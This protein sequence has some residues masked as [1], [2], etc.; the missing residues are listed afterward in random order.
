M[1]RYDF[2]A[3]INAAFDAASAGGYRFT[4]SG[5]ARVAPDVEALH[6]N[7]M[8]TAWSVKYWS[9]DAHARPVVQ[10]AIDAALQLVI[11]QMSTWDP[12]S[13]LSRFNAAQAGSMHAL[14]PELGTVLRHALDM[15]RRTGGA[16][17]PTI[18]PL[19]NLWGFGPRDRQ[20]DG[21]RRRPTPESIAAARARCG[22][23]KVHLDDEGLRQPGGLYIDLS[24]IAKGFAVDL[25]SAR[26]NALGIANSLV[27][28]GGELL[29]HGRRPDASPWRVAVAAPRAR[30]SVGG[31]AGDSTDD[32]AP[33]LAVPLLDQ[34]VATSGDHWH[35]FSQADR[36]YAH[37]LDPR[38]GYPVTHHL[39]SVT[40]V[41]ESCM[42]A[43]ALATILTVIGPDAG[44]VYAVE[45]GIAAVFVR[46]AGADFEE[47]VTPRF[48]ALLS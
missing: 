26:L 21:A 14:P 28:V 10:G 2:N 17:D 6:G 45:Q 32:P 16:F 7:T 25:V 3:A 23:G 33:L 31:S 29:A 13:V 46:R 15:A 38:T 41:H 34:A 30:S 4:A 1:S 39:A 42:Q 22:Y 11:A 24:A 36:E 27:D 12:A 48:Q 18:G 44:H 47:L 19:V 20:Q 5:A 37:T 8:G 43:D 35:F 9:D 40:V